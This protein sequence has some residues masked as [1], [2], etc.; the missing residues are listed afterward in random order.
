MA[1]YT[2][3]AVETS[4]RDLYKQAAPGTVFVCIYFKYDQ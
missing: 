4:A 1:T 2:D 3:I